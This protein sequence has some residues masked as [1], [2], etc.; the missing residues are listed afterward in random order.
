MASP[1]P[2]GSRVVH[3]AL[4]ERYEVDLFRDEPSEGTARITAR[5]FRNDECEFSVTAPA[6]NGGTEP[7]EQ[8]I[9]AEVRRIIA[10]GYWEKDSVHILG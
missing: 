5:V 4:G 9:L 6:S 2:Y 8:A 7:A 1:R 10:E 3:G